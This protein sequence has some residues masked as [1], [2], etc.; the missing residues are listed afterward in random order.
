MISK[1]NLLQKI[2]ENLNESLI[3]LFKLFSEKNP[4]FTG[5]VSIASSGLD[6]LFVFD[7]LQYTEFTFKVQ[8][9]FALG[10]PTGM[11]KK[12]VFNEILEAPKL[13]E[14]LFNISHPSDFLAQRFEPLIN[15]AALE[16]PPKLIDELLNYDASIIDF[17]LPIDT[18]FESSS[19]LWNFSPEFY[20]DSDKLSL[21]LVREIYSEIKVDGMF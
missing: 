20:W 1:K 9:F 7:L 4:S 21:L 3:K 2:L 18:S 10:M 17:T 12:G 8:S 13:C 16:S 19:L 6:S 5:K 14:K 11:L 15:T